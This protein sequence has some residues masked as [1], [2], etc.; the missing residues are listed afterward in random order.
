MQRAHAAGWAAA[1]RAVGGRG[2]AWASRRRGGSP[3]RV[4][5]SHPVGRACRRRRRGCTGPEP[6]AFRGGR[7]HAAAPGRRRLTAGGR[8][9]GRGAADSAVVHLLLDTLVCPYCVH[10]VLVQFVVD[11]CVLET[12]PAARA[13]AVRARAVHPRAGRV[14]HLCSFRSDRVTSARHHRRH[15]GGAPARA[16][17]WR[18]AC[19]RC[20]ACVPHA[21]V[22][23]TCCT[24][25]CCA[26]LRYARLHF[27]C[28]RCVYLL[29][30]PLLCVP[31]LCAFVRCVVCLCSAHL[32]RVEPADIASPSTPA[33]CHALY[34]FPILS[35]ICLLLSCIVPPSLPHFLLVLFLLFIPYFT[36]YSV[37]CLRLCLRKVAQVSLSAAEH[38]GHL[39]SH[40]FFCPISCLCCFLPCAMRF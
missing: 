1:R 2:R 11:L 25:A 39:I 31:A 6:G 29:C 40:T 24:Y 21:R 13:H 23:C 7:R 18:C 27:P 30:L 15:R 14:V 12:M 36:A 38:P 32:H 8:G 9:H 4:C 16:L 34:P 20:R 3:G 26:C 22:A 35:H 37:P 33:T 5:R 19:L 10:G 28:S 17:C